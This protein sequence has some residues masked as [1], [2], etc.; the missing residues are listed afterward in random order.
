MKYNDLNANG[1]RDAGEPVLPDWEIRAYA[2]ANGNGAVDAGETFVSDTTDANGLYS[3]SLNPGNY[4][5]C[6]VLQATW[7]Q[8]EPAGPD[9]CSATGLGADGYAITVT[10]GSSDTDNEFGNY[11]NA[12]ISGMKFKD[13]DAD[14]VKDAGEIGLGGWVIH[15][16]GPGGSTASTTTAADGTYSFSGLTPGDYVVCEQTSG[17]TG[18]VQSFPGGHGLHNAIGAAGDAGSRR[19]QPDPDIRTDA[20]RPR[21]R[22]HAVVRRDVSFT[23][24]ADLPVDQGGGDATHTTEIT[25]KDKDG[26]TVGSDAD[27]DGDATTTNLKTSA[28]TVTCTIS[29]VDP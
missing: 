1:D 10:S 7:I 11:Q 19:L 15:L 21:L 27:N 25:C 14:G 28:S 17:K 5:V 18:W 26:N 3:F 20:R 9:E 24:L 23:A 2:D 12:T 4:V 22:Q 13:A 6:E 8:S 16:F 29:F